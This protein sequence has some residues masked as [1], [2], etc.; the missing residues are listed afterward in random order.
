VFAEIAEALR[1]TVNKQ[2]HKRRKLLVEV[3]AGELLDKLSILQIKSQLMTDPEK[4]RNVE[5]E[6]NALLAVRQTLPESSELAALEEQ[7]TNI[8]EQ[9]WEIED[10][11]RDCE[12]ECDF[13]QR[14]IELARSVYHTNDRR[15]ALKR[16]INELLGSTIVEEKSYAEYPGT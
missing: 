2:G 7:L 9:L 14:F 8:N 1:E 3:S 12:R 15:S 16:A 6:T 10:A 4:L 5:V 13:G 11:I